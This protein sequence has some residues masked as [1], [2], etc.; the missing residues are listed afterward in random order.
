MERICKPIFFFF[1]FFFFFFLF[2]TDHACS[3]M[4]AIPLIRHQLASKRFLELDS[5]FE[6]IVFKEEYKRVF[7]AGASQVMLQ[8]CSRKWSS[9]RVVDFF[10]P[11]VMDAAVNVFRDQWFDTVL[12]LGILFC[13][14]ILV[15]CAHSWLTWTKFL[16][17]LSF[18]LLVGVYMLSE[19][20]R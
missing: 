1:F 7:S 19:G 17:L 2:S 3:Y 9:S 16:C 6:K 5:S 8:A 15:L 20:V 4:E 13:W 18:A 11:Q 10:F 14:I 12:G